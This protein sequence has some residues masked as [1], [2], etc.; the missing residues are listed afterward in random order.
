MK[1]TVAGNGRAFSFLERQGIGAAE[2]HLFTPTPGSIL[3]WRSKVLQ[4]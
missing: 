4:F 1:S 2:T 3:F